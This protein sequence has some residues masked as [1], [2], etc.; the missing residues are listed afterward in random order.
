L[1]QRL[2]SSLLPLL[3][4][5]AD[6]RFHSGE[7]L[8]ERLAM[9]RA[10][11]CNLL[12]Q[13]ESLGLAIHALRGRGYRLAHA[14]DWLDADRVRGAL[15]ARAAHFTLRIVDS[16][17]STNRALLEAAQRGAPDGTVLAAEHQ[18][19]GRGRRGRAWQS[20]LGG[21]LAFSVLWRF[22]AGIAALG[23]LSLAAGLA[24]ARAVNRHSRHR[25]GLKWPNDVLVGHRKLAGILVEVQGDSEGPSLAVVGIG[26]NVRL[27]P[28]QREAIDQAVVD[29]AEMGVTCGRN[30]LLA[31]CLAELH[32]VVVRLR[33]DGFRA[34]RAEWEAHHAHAGAPVTLT[35]PDART[36]HGIAAGVDERGAFLLTDDS[37][38]T[39]AF[40][41]GEISLRPRR[42]QP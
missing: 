25:A 10:N 30:T 2:P 26:L 40:H 23:G 35:L 11:V 28:A 17:D 31:A 4:C 18:F 20:A 13:A 27:P 15:G 39:R 22:D 38:V 37:G 5:L 16:V 9:S 21:S 6:G 12:H 41:G 34:L 19:A 7:V 33:R 29:L 42:R 1:P 14:A 36:L 24:V 32:D 8:A 3:R